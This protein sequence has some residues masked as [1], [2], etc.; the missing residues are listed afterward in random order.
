MQ[1]KSS[2]YIAYVSVYMYMYLCVKL[3]S[4]KTRKYI[5][6]KVNIELLFTMFL[7]IHSILYPYF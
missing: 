3:Y 2:C 6:I 4:D 1:A 7:L 5:I